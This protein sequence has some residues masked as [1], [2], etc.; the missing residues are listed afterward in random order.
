MSKFA[1]L[2]TSLAMEDDDLIKM[3]ESAEV[4][5]EIESDMADSQ[6]EMAAIEDYEEAIDEGMDGAQ[7]LDNTT[8]KMEKLSEKNDGLSDDAVEM[9]EVSLE[10][11]YRRMRLPYSKKTKRVMPALESFSTSSSRKETSRLAIEEIK[12]QGAKI[13]E[14]IKEFFKKL[15]ESLVVAINNVVGIATKLDTYADALEKRVASLE[16]KEAKEREFEDSSLMSAFGFNGKVDAGV[17]ST[18]LKGQ[19]NLSEGIVKAVTD[20]AGVITGKAVAVINSSNSQTDDVK[21]I[22]DGNWKSIMGRLGGLSSFGKSSVNALTVT[23]PVVGGKKIVLNNDAG[24]IKVSEEKDQYKTAGKVK[25]L[26]AGEMTTII[27]D[28]RELLKSTEGYKEK[29]KSGEKV[30][31]EI[32]R[33]IDEAI[34]ALKKK[35]DTKRDQKSLSTVRE[36]VTSA[37]KAQF[38][39]LRMT[40]SYNSSAAKFALNYV[41]RSMKQYGEAAAEPE[42]K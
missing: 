23:L 7:Q 10:D 8:E 5:A 4:P 15:W 12:E 25:T 22:A 17:V 19:N 20:Y 14:R 11:I 31:K 6:Q 41:A 1:K 21:K 2:Y 16:G 3:S 9:A 42:K 29:I 30:V 38:Q 28:A 36:S 40:A 24:V 27:G 35:E 13:W 33:V 37:G 32:E 39:V 18:V 26:A 34:K